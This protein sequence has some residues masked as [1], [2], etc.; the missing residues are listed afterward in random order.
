MNHRENK[1]PNIKA[2][3]EINL[4]FQSNSLPDILHVA[5]YNC[6]AT[7]SVQN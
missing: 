5:S 4:L 6:A 1:H 7:A 3:L 2:S